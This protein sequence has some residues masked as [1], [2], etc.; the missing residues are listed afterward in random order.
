MPSNLADLDIRA[1]QDQCRD[2]DIPWKGVSSAEEL[3]KLLSK[4]E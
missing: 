2:R 4:P 1:L 3:R